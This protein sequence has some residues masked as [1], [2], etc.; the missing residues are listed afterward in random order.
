MDIRQALLSG[1]LLLPCTSLLGAGAR[2]PAGVNSARARNEAGTGWAIIIG[3]N[4]YENQGIGSLQFC[5]EDARELLNVL[6]TNCGYPR[7]N[8]RLMLDGS[9]IR[10]MRP[11]H[12]N[13]YGTLGSWLRL[14]KPQDI[15][16]VYFA[17]HC[18]EDEKQSYLLPQDAI[19]S[20]PALTGI[21][22]SHVKDFLRKCPAK[23]KVL[24][25]DACHSGEGRGLGRMKTDWTDDSEG[26]VC[27]TSCGIGEKSYEWPEKKH[28]AFSWFFLA[29]LRGLADANRD[30]LIRASEVN[31]YLSEEVRRW[32]AER[33][34]RQSP[35]FVA[36]VQGDPVLASWSP[37]RDELAQPTAERT[38]TKPVQSKDDGRYDLVLLKS[39]RVMECEATEIGDKV[40]VRKGTMR[41]VIPRDQVSEIRHGQGKHK[42]SGSPS[43]QKKPQALRIPVWRKGDLKVELLRTEFPLRGEEASCV[44]FLF[45]FTNERK[46]RADIHLDGCHIRMTTSHE[47]PEPMRSHID[48]DLSHG[49]PLIHRS[50]SHRLKS[51]PERFDLTM[52]VQGSKEWRA[53]FRKVRIGVFGQK[54]TTKSTSGQGTRPT[55]SWEGEAIR[56]EILEARFHTRGEQASCVELRFRFTNAR[57]DG[58]DVHLYR[59]HVSLTPDRE[60]TVSEWCHIDKALSQGVPLVQRFLSPRLDRKPDWLGMTVDIQGTRPCRAKFTR[61]PVTAGSTRAR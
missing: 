48:K 21:P 36:A 26:L 40:I 32:A 6:V 2:G 19:A 54:R 39:G 22:L 9:P 28:G 45:R 10:S 29:G 16:L 20:Q 1:L 47:T 60:A 3:I 58:A 18:I 24:I 51:K 41:T 5:A 7:K 12:S 4:R 33:R 52:A 46:D 50:V 14:S 56:V 17:G 25:V 30:G 61:V 23:R 8:C 34:L 44:V 15:A 42:L 13:I 57:R 37:P 27:I 31:L 59:C 49:V 38:H 53:T 55:L 11:T 35:K 43:P